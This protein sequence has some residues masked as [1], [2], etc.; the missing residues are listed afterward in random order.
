MCVR[1]YLYLNLPLFD[2]LMKPGHLRAKYI[3][4]V[5]AG[6][7]Y[8]FVESATKAGCETLAE[9]VDWL[10]KHWAAFQP[11]QRTHRIFYKAR[12]D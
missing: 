5:S 6:L 12:C 8:N 11:L 4:N 2:L 7:V 1:Q 10:V 3:Y 9:P